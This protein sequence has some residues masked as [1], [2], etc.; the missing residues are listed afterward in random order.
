MAQFSNRPDEWRAALDAA[1][2]R[3]LVLRGR[4]QVSCR[5]RK[6]QARY[7]RCEIQG[8]LLEGGL[9]SLESVANRHKPIRGSSLAEQALHLSCIQEDTGRWRPNRRAVVAVV[10]V[11]R[12]RL[13]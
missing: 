12:L 6:N 13:L 9:R 7:R 2:F 10:A 3:Q 5:Y 4:H 11:R 1:L 8:S